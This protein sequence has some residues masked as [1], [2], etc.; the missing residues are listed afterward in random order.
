MV[1]H[2]DHIIR[3]PADVITATPDC[4]DVGA[5]YS[6]QVN[7]IGEPNNCNNTVLTFGSHFIGTI[8][9]VPSNWTK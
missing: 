1:I 4:P 9:N 3:G 8:D 5:S 2:L 7:G 6:Q